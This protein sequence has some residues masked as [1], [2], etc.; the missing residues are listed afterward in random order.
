VGIAASAGGLAALTVVLGAIPPDFPLPVLVVEHQPPGAPSS[1]AA[2][3]ERHTE[4]EVKVAEDGE[5]VRAGTVY[6][7]PPDRHMLL[8]AD[9]RIDLSDAEPVGFHRPSANVLFDSLAQH[10]AS[11]AVVVVL[12]GMRRDGADGVVAV[13][14]A[15]GCVLAQDEATSQ[16]FGMPAAAIA[17]GAVDRVLPLGA[18]GP[19]LTSLGMKASVA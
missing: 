7:A 16:F 10:A 11:G 14:A 1:L 9:W 15:G 19:A 3:L 18:I 13:K 6:V 8:A 4:L 2:I 17:T 5:Q 12:S